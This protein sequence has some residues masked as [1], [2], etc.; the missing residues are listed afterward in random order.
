[1][2]P[3]LGRGGE[4]GSEGSSS[5]VRSLGA[6]GLPQRRSGVEVR[7]GSGD[8]EG[9]RRVGA[10]GGEYEF[11]YDGRVS[12]CCWPSWV[13][14]GGYV[15]REEILCGGQCDGDSV[16]PPRGWPRSGRVPTADAVGYRLSVLRTCRLRSESLRGL[17]GE[18][19]GATAEELPG[20]VGTG[21]SSGPGKRTGSGFLRPLPAAC[22]VRVHPPV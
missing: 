6:G 3:G 10:D 1:M 14:G 11:E 4:V 7:P 16:A 18:V 13:K 15:D 12:W 22:P 5:E 19:L 20:V 2:R 9:G 17:V 21:S 8:E